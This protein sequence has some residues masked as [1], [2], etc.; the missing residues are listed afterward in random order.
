MTPD[1]SIETLRAIFDAVPERVAVLDAEGRYRYLNPAMIA[2][3]GRPLE[4]L[5]GRRVREVAADT[6]ALAAFE[7]QCEAVLRTGRPLT[8]LVTIDSPA[9]ATVE[10]SVSP[11]VTRDDGA[12]TRALLLILRDVS[13]RAAA[14]RL[15]RDREAELRLTVDGIQ[16]H[17]VTLLDA[18]GRIVRINP[19]GERIFGWTA[20]DVR[21]R[22]LAIFFTEPDLVAG[23]PSEELRVARERG[24]FTAEGWRRRRD[25]TAFYASSS[26][27]ALIDGEGVHHGFVK[28]VADMTERKRNEDLLRFVTEVSGVLASSLEYEAT[29]ANAVRLAVPALAD[30]AA[31][32]ILDQGEIRRLAVAHVDPDKVRLAHELWRRRPPAMTDPSGLAAVIRT[33]EPEVVAAIDDA[34]LVAAID[35]LE[36]LALIR[37]LGLRSSMIVP[38]F[39]RGRAI[40]ALTLVSAESG[41]RFGESDLR[42]AQDL[43]R[44]ASVA[45][46]NA[47]LY[48]ES[49]DANRLKDEFLGVVS[50]E[51]RTPL[52]AMLGWVRILRTTTLPE[53]QQAR[54]LETIERNVRAQTRL[55]EDLLDVS[56]IVTGKLS[57]SLRSADVDAIVRAAAEVVGAAAEAKHIALELELDPALGPVLVDA[58]RLQQ[59]VWNLLVNAVKF[60]P[61]GG[62]VRARVAHDEQ[63]LTVEVSDTGVGISPEFLPHI[64]ERFRQAEQDL[65]RAHGGLG[66]GLAIVR[67]LTELHGGTAHAASEG[68]GRGATFTIR[69][70]IRRAGERAVDRPSPITGALPAVAPAGE[71]PDLGGARVLVVDDDPDTRELLETLLTMHGAAVRAVSG[72]AAA[73]DALDRFDPEILVSDIAMPETDGYQLLDAVRARARAEGKPSIPAVAVSAHARSEDRL[74]ALHAGFQAHL[75]KPVDT[76]ELIATVRSLK[77]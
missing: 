44:R 64:F 31:C 56:R 41:R 25:G 30:W 60:T 42:L 23:L 36:L 51:L 5:L 67:H 72:A 50:H 34:L 18:E 75:A 9:G 20:E 8:H 58:D 76:E 4:A 13:E 71:R 74:R 53:A 63:A 17:A 66:L 3:F 22:P 26:L 46:E 37:T 70:P 19:A 2:A 61:A 47:L 68:A 40:G 21:G 48:R 52:G 35:D 54:A 65:T 55:V 24:R 16:E 1:L 73:L 10:Y 33:G 43:A 6:D 7:R 14:L 45:I 69:L 11:I 77:G 39:V 28:V 49:R 57:L 15:A 32:D 62:R 29:I 27:S 59:I 12:E 38:L